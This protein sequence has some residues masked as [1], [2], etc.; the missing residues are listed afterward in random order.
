MFG[1]CFIVGG[2][3]FGY[4]GEMNLQLDNWQLV[5]VGDGEE[6]EGEDDLWCILGLVCYVGELQ[7][8]DWLEDYGWYGE[9]LV[10]LDDEMGDIG[11]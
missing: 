3:L 8:G 1:Q 7:V 2:G 9:L 11:N 10:G 5:G 6:D 4:F